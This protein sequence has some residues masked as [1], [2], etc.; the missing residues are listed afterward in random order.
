[1]GMDYPQLM[2]IRPMDYI[3]DMT[4]EEHEKLRNSIISR[5]SACS[6]SEASKIMFRAAMIAFLI[7]NS[8]INYNV[9]NW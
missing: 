7:D 6:F 9:W 2:K 3:L 8:V 5:Q 4:P 1:M